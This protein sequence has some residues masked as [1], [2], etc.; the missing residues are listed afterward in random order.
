MLSMKM[1]SIT[2]FIKAISDITM[3]SIRFSMIMFIIATFG[4][5]MSG[6]KCLV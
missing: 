2:L 1:F 5:T 6:I 4:K 3:T